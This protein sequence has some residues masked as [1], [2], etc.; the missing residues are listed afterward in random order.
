MNKWDQRMVMLAKEISLWSK[1]NQRQVGCIITTDTY[2]ILSTGYNGYPPNIDDDDLNNRLLKTVHAEINA[3][4]SIP[5][6]W[7]NL[8][9]YIYGGHPCAQCASA[10]LQK[11]IT[12]LFCPPI[13]TETSWQES[14]IVA[15]Q[16]LEK[17]DFLK[18]RTVFY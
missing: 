11:P 13:D 9:M 17:A 18:Y 5:G 4:L 3:L 16:L 8:R 12:H 6:T 1:D 15:Q 7:R 2:R 14:M 10:I